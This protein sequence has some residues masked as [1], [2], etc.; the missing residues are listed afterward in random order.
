MYSIP[1]PR[2]P[3]FPLP[4]ADDRV[5]PPEEQ[6]SVKFRDYWVMASKYRWTI[7]ACTI[8]VGAFSAMSLL[9]KAPTYTATATL[10]IEPQMPN[11]LGD[12]QPGYGGGPAV[13]LYYKTQLNL[14]QSRSLAARVIR[15]LGFDRDSRL[16]THTEAPPSRLQIYWGQTVGS[17]SEWVQ[18]MGLL[19]WLQEQATP[20]EE[21]AQPE[22]FEF[23]V[24]PGLIDTYLMRLKINYVVDSQLITVGFTSLDSSFSREVANAHANM[25]IR[26]SLLTRFEMT[27]GAR[28]F[29]EERLGELKVKLAKSEEELQSVASKT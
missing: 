11:I 17:I 15:D 26:T 12:A 16:R 9:G 25:F 22:T 5:F 8:L 7:V 13:D 14:L 23:G 10:F 29:L 4:P 2:H 24:H 3:S 18:E 6:E 1:P 21:R 27:A 20:V 19:K 28:Q